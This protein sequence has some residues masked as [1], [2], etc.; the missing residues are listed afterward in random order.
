[1]YGMHNGMHNVLCF[2]GILEISVIILS[3]ILIQ[4]IS[5]VFMCVVNGLLTTENVAWPNITKN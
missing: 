4:R 5:C 3:F 2:A 1:M